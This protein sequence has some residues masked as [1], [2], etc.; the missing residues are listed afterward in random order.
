MLG[1][2]QQ[3]SVKMKAQSGCLPRFA[4]PHFDLKIVSWR[5]SSQSRRY[6]KLPSRLTKGCL[7]NPIVSYRTDTDGEIKPFGMLKNEEA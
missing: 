5:D 1:L 3:F 2:V 4:G 6:L 7:Y